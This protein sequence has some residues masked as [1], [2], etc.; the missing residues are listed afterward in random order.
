[1][2]SEGEGD[3][4]EG[5]GQACRL[6]PTEALAEEEEAGEGGDK[7]DPDI[8]QGVVESRGQ[9][10]EGAE[11]AGGATDVSDS[12]QGAPA[13]SDPGDLVLAE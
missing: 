10:A 7:D 3:G 8:V 5:K 12:E 2:R 9:D 4:N 6:P 11:H 13:G 1:M